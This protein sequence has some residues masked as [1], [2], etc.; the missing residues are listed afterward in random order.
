MRRRAAALMTALAL[1]TFAAC[2]GASGGDFESLR[3]EVSAAGDISLSADVT[4][5]FDPNFADVYEKRNSAR[6]N[7]GMG[8]CKYTGARGKSGAPDASAELV[9]YTRKVLECIERSA[10]NV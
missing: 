6:I 8:L 2:G 9:A 4:A 3:A 5:A 1:L 10:E 7:Y